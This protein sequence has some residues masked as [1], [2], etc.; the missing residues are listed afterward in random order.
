MK[1]NRSL[2]I[3]LIIIVPVAIWFLRQNNES[4]LNADESDFSIADTSLVT[5]IFIADKKDRSVL[6][7]RTDKGWVLDNKFLANAHAVELFLGTISKIEIKAPVPLA[8]RDNIVKR[9]AGIAIKTEIYEKAWRINFGDNFKFFPYEKLAKVYYVGDVTQN[10]L[11]TYM[12][13]EGA[14]EPFIAYIPGFRGFLTPYYSPKTD[15]WRSHRVYKNDLTEIK[16]V[17]LT[18]PDMPEEN[19]RVDVA[20]DGSYSLSG[21]V[22]NSA[23]TNYDTLK[24]LNLL[25]SFNDLRYESRLNNELPAIMIDSIVNSTPMFNLDL[26]DDNDDTIEVVGFKKNYLSEEVRDEAYWKL[27]PLDSDRFYGLINDGEDFVLL[28]YYTFDKVT[29]P[30]SHYTE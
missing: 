17:S 15:D 16:Q 23:I 8:A 28:Q 27:I 30:L 9:M 21:G 14:P 13:M 2:I 29:Y 11:G 22:D 19:L 26:I 5:K 24:I 1:K 20:V 25:T 12:L 7:E 6:L 10:N 4:T 3:L 18:F